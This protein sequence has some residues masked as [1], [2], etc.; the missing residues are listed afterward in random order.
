M[1]EAGLCAPKNQPKCDGLDQMVSGVVIEVLR[2]QAKFC[3][4]DSSSDKAQE[5]SDGD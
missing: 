5:N 4:L 3:L 1:R 2:V